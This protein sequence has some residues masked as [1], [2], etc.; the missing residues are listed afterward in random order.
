MQDGSVDEAL[1]DHLEHA[2]TE[3]ENAKREAFNEAVKR[4]RAEKDA[5]DAIRRVNIFSFTYFIH[6]FFSSFLFKL[7]DIDL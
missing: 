7:L 6:E 2:F 3:A 5:I 4:R 1:Y